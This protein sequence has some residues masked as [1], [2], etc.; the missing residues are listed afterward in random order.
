M[1]QNYTLVVLSLL[2]YIALIGLGGLLKYATNR[3]EETAPDWK[4]LDWV[5]YWVLNP[6]LLFTSA[7]MKPLTLSVVFANGGWVWALMLTGLLFG[8]VLWSLKGLPAVEAASRAQTAWRFNSVVG[9]AATSLISPEA[10][11]IMAIFVGASVPFANM[12]AVVALAMSSGKRKKGWVFHCVSSVLLNPFFIASLGG[13][14]FG[15]TF[16]GDPNVMDNVVVDLIL[17]FLKLLSEA[18]IPISLIAVGTAVIWANLF[19]FNKISFYL[20]SV[21]FVVRPSLVWGA[22][23]VLPIPV[24]TAAV[25]IIFASLPTSASSH[26]LGAA[27][28]AKREPTALIVSQSTIL[29]CLALPI[30]MTVALKLL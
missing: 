7:A 1:L 30:W 26:I 29:A 18:A 19:R 12:L 27:Y 22:S 28:G 20:H 16:R 21:K 14:L 5:C 2:P 3:N 4:T 13:L 17:R 9:L 10:L 24:V 15:L 11:Q 23:V 8:S 25:L 6:A